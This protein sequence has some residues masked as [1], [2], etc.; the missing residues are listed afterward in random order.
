MTAVEMMTK[1]PITAK[2]EM[3]AFAA[4][5]LMEDRPQQI[6]VLPVVDAENKCV[7]LLRL[8]DVVSSGL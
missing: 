5:K 7:G 3:L 1:N 6:S 4:L 8:H 2:P